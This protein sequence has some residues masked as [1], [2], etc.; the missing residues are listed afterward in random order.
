VSERERDHH[1]IIQLGFIFQ[2]R[3]PREFTCFSNITEPLSTAA[4]PSFLFSTPAVKLYKAD[5]INFHREPFT[6]RV[7]W[8]GNT[9]KAEVF[10]RDGIFMA[11]FFSQQL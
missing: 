2:L 7:I 4:S 1:S 5:V 3:K 8:S 11:T 6:L 10:Y 9:L